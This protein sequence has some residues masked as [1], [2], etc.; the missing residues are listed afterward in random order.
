MF[1]ISV[2]FPDKSVSES[3]VLF[4]WEVVVWMLFTYCS[5]KFSDSFIFTVI[6]ACFSLSTSFPES[7]SGSRIEQ[8]YDALFFKAIFRN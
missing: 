7:K 4:M 6:C 5:F 1:K 8:G 3:L 2:N